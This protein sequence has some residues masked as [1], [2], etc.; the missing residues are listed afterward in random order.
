MKIRIIHLALLSALLPL[1]NLYA[2]C[3]GEF[4]LPSADGTKICRSQL[5][6][7]A[8]LIDFWASWCP[9]CRQSL[10]W[11][12]EIQKDSSPSK[13]SFLAINVDQNRADA[14]D[15]LGEIPAGLKV[16]FDSEGTIAE[17]CDFKAIP[18]SI[19]IDAKGAIVH[20]WSGSSEA[21]HQ[22]MMDGLK[23]LEGSHG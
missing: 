21:I 16:V 8:V 1:S 13:T 19:L 7:K 20:Q 11:L 2:D 12:S 14:D 4:C 10:H 15:V 3:L 5:R 22:E 23:K 9:N 17:R 18:A 6:G